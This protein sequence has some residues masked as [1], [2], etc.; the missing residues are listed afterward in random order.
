[1][2]STVFAVL[3][4]LSLHSS[5]Y[6]IT[7]TKYEARTWVK[8]FYEL[9]I[10]AQE[11]GV[12]GLRTYAT[13]DEILLVDEYSLRD[14]SSDND[15]DYDLRQ[16][17]LFI[18]SSLSRSTEFPENQDGNPLI[19]CLYDKKRANGLWGAIA[20][21]SFSIS[22]Q[23][24]TLWDTHE[25]N[26]SIEEM[27]EDTTEIEERNELVKHLYKEQHLASHEA[28]LRSQTKVFIPNGNYLWA[29]RKRLFPLLSFCKTTQSQIKAL[30]GPILKQVIKK[31]TEL[32]LACQTWTEGAFDKNVLLN[33]TPESEATLTMYNSEHSFE[34]EDGETRLF[35]LHVSFTPTAGRIFFYPH[36]KATG[37]HIIYMGHIGKKLPNVSY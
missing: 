14:W 28:W 7:A 15:V 16:S 1:M 26:V 36:V 37:E 2:N 25:L 5:S 9:L 21:D 12:K 19:E 3:N 33:C 6:P 10:K 17:I 4:E 31:L 13:F 29:Y 27:D 23:S 18:F 35:S 34:C 24:Q 30:N 20:L 22:L 11:Q 8:T 32:Q